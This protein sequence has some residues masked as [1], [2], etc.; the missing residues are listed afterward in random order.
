MESLSVW[1]Y[2]KMRARDLDRSPHRIYIRI[3]SR[4]P[5]I[6]E[7]LRDRQLGQCAGLVDSH[8]ARRYC[9]NRIGKKAQCDHIVEL[10]YF[11]TDRRKNL[12]LLC[13]WCHQWKT[14]MNRVRQRWF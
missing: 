5:T 7:W 11:G 1:V 8:G 14:R 6:R 9:S 12:Q 4:D 2:R 10:R 13:K 3:A